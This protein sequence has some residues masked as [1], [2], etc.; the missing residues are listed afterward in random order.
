MCRVGGATIYS[1]FI[2]AL[3]RDAH[4]SC[5]VRIPTRVHV[6]HKQSCNVGSAFPRENSRTR[7]LAVREYKHSLERGL[8]LF[9]RS[10]QNLAHQ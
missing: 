8:R 3:P 6:C 10:T 7:I 2:L 4:V 1:I 5:V 9:C